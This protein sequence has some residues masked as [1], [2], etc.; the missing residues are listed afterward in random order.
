MPARKSDFSIA[1][2][3]C[4]QAENENSQGETAKARW[5]IPMIHSGILKR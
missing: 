4:P 5:I 1:V 3:I 2:S